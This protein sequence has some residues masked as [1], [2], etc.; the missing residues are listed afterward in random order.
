MPMLCYA[1]RC[2]A[3]SCSVV[4]A[5]LSRSSTCFYVCTS[6]PHMCMCVP[7][8]LP[9]CLLACLSAWLSVCVPVCLLV[10]LSVRPS[11]RRSV[12]LFVSLSLCGCGCILEAGLCS[13]MLCRLCCEAS[14]FHMLSSI[15]VSHSLP[16]C[17]VRTINTYDMSAYA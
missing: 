17:L 9:A 15:Y 11:V 14:F 4:I 16:L 13:S 12:C 7:G 2:C 6:L 5:C 10:P 3:I 1:M 8:C